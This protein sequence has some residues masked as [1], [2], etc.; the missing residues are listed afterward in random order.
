MLKVLFTSFLGL[1]LLTGCSPSVQ[2]KIVVFHKLPTIEK[3]DTIYYSFDKTGE[4]KTIE[5]S[6]YFDKL[7]DK[8]KIY[9]YFENE[10]N[11]DYIVKF[12]YEIDNGTSIPYSTSTPI[13]GKT[14]GG[15]KY[16]SGSINGQYKSG[17][18]TTPTTYGVV[19]TITSSGVTTNYNRLLKLKIYSKTNQE[20]YSAKV[21]SKGSSSTLIEVI[22]EMLEGLFKEFPGDTQQVR[23]ESIIMKKNQ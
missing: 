1:F 11:Y 17:Y 7:K 13:Y 5:D 10:N 14:G 8:F 21:I 9:N 22:D 4:Q 20:V 6:V 12:T 15:T 18:I 19:N 2:S 23:T 3:N 16:V